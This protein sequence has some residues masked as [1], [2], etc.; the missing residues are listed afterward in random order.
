MATVGQI[1]KQCGVAPWRVSH[2]FYSGKLR[3][4]LCPIVSGRRL[5]PDDYVPHVVAALKRSGV[6]VRE[7][8]RE[9]AHA[10]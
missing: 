8:E 7:I 4:D 2:L 5:I 9:A 1:A 3:D 6:A 10:S